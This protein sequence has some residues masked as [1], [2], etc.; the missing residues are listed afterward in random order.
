LGRHPEGNQTVLTEMRS[1]RHIFVPLLLAGSP[2]W[3]DATAHIIVQRSSMAGFQYYEGRGVWKEM[4]VGEPL[5]LVRERDNPHDPDAVRLE[6]RGHTLGY[7]PRH[8]NRHLARQID[9][10]AALTARITALQKSR[11]GRNRVSY[12][13][14]V[15]LR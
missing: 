14:S 8:E 3:G 4:K 15:P 13:I 2:A 9:Y 11:N 12:E 5:T 6:W 1:A 7:V 10:G